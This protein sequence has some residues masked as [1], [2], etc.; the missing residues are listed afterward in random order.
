MALMEVPALQ[1]WPD[2][3]LPSLALGPHFWYLADKDRLDVNDGDY[4]RIR[5]ELAADGRHRPMDARTRRHPPSRS[6]SQYDETEPAIGVPIEAHATA[7]TLTQGGI[8]T[9]MGIAQGVAM[10]AHDLPIATVAAEVVLPLETARDTD[11]GAGPLGLQP[12]GIVRQSSGAA[13]PPPPF[14]EI[15]AILR[16][17][18]V[19]TQAEAPSL[20]N[21]IDI[22]V[23][24]LGVDAT[25]TSSIGRPVLACLCPPDH[26]RTSPAA[27]TL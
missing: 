17:E 26:M 5:S 4:Y 12:P 14:S 19:I 7:D 15:A 16:R 27:Y 21:V 8:A 9:V 22:A 18:L 10:N 3:H 13:A 25:T 11:H 1:E 6:L 24:M 20:R 2:E 23:S